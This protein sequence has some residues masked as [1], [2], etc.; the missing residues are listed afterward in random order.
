MSPDYTHGVETSET[1]TAAR[2]IH[3][4]ILIAM[5]DATE[6]LG[7]L[8]TLA[9]GRRHPDALP[10]LCTL[11][12]GTA[13]RDPGKF[14]HALRHAFETV[15]DLGAREGAILQGNYVEDAIRVYIVLFLGSTEGEAR[16]VGA[17]EAVHQIAAE[18]FDQTRLEVHVLA[19]LPDLA[20]LVDRTSRYALAYRQLATIDRLGDPARPLGLRIGA[21]TDFRWILDCRTRSGAH[22]GRLDDVLEPAAETIALLLEGRNTD[23][24]IAVGQATDRLTRSVH[25]R[26]AGYSTFGAALLVHRRRP[27]ARLLTA[28][29]ALEHLRQYGRGH[30]LF[31]PVDDGMR[32]NARPEITANLEAK[33]LEWAD[34]IRLTARLDEVLDETPPAPDAPRDVRDRFR[35]WQSR[36]RA[37]AIDDLRSE[38]GAAVKQ[39]L[40]SGGLAHAHAALRA[41]GSEPADDESTVSLPVSL[42]NLQA[43]LRDELERVL[44][45]A[46]LRDQIADLTRA[47][48]DA[49]LALEEDRGTR[50]VGEGPAVEDDEAREAPTPMPDSEDD[51]HAVDADSE[52]TTGAD[53]KI[54]PPLSASIQASLEVIS[55]R[56]ASLERELQRRERLLDPSIPPDRLEAELLELLS[57]DDPDTS[58]AN[59]GLEPPPAP[60]AGVRPPLRKRLIHRVRSIFGRT[61]SRM[62]PAVPTSPTI[63][64]REPESAA[65]SIPERRRWLDDYARILDDI[66]VALDAHATAAVEAAEFYENTVDALTDEVTRSANFVTST[67]EPAALDRYRSQYLPRLRE[68]ITARNACHLPRYFRIDPPEMRPFE[69]PLN[70]ALDGFDEALDAIAGEHL[71]PL[72]AETVSDVLAGRTPAGVIGSIGNVARMLLE[73]S[74]PLA[75]PAPLTDADTVSVERWV[76]ATRSTLELFQSNSAAE[77]VLAQEGCRKL[78]LPDDETIVF[79]SAHH[80]FAAQ[81][82][83]KLLTFRSASLR[84]HEIDAIED[85]PVSLEALAVG[86]TGRVLRTLVLALRL[87][88][89]EQ[90]ARGIRVTDD[91][92]LPAD[93]VDAVRSF[94]T[95]A[96]AQTALRI[97]EDRIDAFLQSPDGLDRLHDAADAP[98]LSPLER[99]IV[100][101][102]LAEVVPE[103]VPVAPR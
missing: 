67:V 62:E 31:D 13:G 73:A 4:A 29:A 3:P 64:N 78:Y 44:G 16:M 14:D 101:E 17:V 96:H 79:F 84:D 66:R 7:P 102:T 22:A 90:N 81:A 54:Q 91:L 6:R 86:P 33:L 98:G 72:L 37:A 45:L 60:A 39:W 12:S 74:Q 53:G 75:R 57:K 11:R 34:S 48:A 69:H 52:A 40:G 56:R 87:G 21:P 63:T 50:T 61:E 89:V 77:A 49:R 93:L 5:D 20:Q 58:M 76:L 83:R 71:A 27:L 41:L 36:R 25:G 30:P 15:T 10:F 24:I 42:S 88:L 26:V 82:I 8:V 51:T 55:R 95:H 92:M 46:E 38:L 94:T 47:E 65:R 97:L 1:S 68:A 43:R 2:W 103:Q 19:L 23:P 28:H 35:T 80:G 59:Q 99:R 9:L 85:E 18:F 70:V 32:T 100:L